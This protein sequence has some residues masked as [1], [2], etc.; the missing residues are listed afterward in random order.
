VLPASSE[1][2]IYIAMTRLLLRR[3]AHHW[4]LRQLLRAATG[5]DA[6]RAACCV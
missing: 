1:A 4:L 5:G 6:V 3:L 2:M